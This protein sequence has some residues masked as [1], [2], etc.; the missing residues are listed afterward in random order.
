[1]HTDI[2]QHAEI[3]QLAAVS[4]PNLV[5]LVLATTP[6]STEAEANRIRFGTLI[7]R[8]VAGLTALGGDPTEIAKTEAGLRAL[9]DDVYLWRYLSR[10][11]VVFAAPDRTISYRLPNEL[12]TEWFAGEQFRIVPILRTLA[13][14]HEATVLALSQNAARLIGI[15]PDHRGVE[16][17]VPELPTDLLD[18]FNVEDPGIDSHRRRLH[19]PEGQTARLLAYARAV[20]R[21][22]LPTL[23]GRPHPLI[24]ASTQPLEGLYRSVTSAANLLAA[25]IEGNPDEL[26]A[27]DLDEAARSIL[28]AHYAA[29]LA[30]LRER[31][32]TRR[33]SGRAVTDLT[34]V[35]RS[36]VAGAVATLY[37]DL[38]AHPVGTL[39]REFG[40]VSSEDTPGRSLIDDIAGQ[41]LAHGGR[42]LVLRSEDVPGGGQMG[43]EVR[44]NV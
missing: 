13:F 23:R 16:L 25:T 2:P 5:T 17:P 18:T 34:D 44:F 4:R 42:V 9:H 30:T 3:Q 19:G 1:M 41:V 40:A 31:F 6:V 15:G 39:D 7:S 28:D 8:A 21:A 24:L 20:D 36:S 22:I 11:L 14:S 29:E 12:E 43:A 26:S 27:A 35:A 10:T 33:A 37:V 32:E 38:D